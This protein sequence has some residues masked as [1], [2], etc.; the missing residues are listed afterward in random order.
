MNNLATPAEM[1]EDILSN[2]ELT[3]KISSGAFMGLLE[4]R[5]VEEQEKPTCGKQAG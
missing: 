5:H 3:A 1:V 4:M 2:Q